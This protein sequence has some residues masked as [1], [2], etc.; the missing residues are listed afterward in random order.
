LERQHT[1][2]T[3]RILASQRFLSGTYGL[4][5]EVADQS[6]SVAPGG[7]VGFTNDNVQADSKSNSSSVPGRLCPNSLN[8]P[9]DLGRT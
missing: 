5:A 7:I 4:I 2:L 1:L 9:G 6:L 8:L 3:D